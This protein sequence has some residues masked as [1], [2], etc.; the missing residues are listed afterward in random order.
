MVNET[1]YLDGVDALSVGIRLREP[2]TF[3]GATPIIDTQKIPGRN[4]VLT[5][6]T[7]AYKNRTAEARC[8]S[9]EENVQNAVAR[10]SAFL[11][12]K[13]GYRRLECS[14]DTD[15]FW[16]AMVSNGAS[17]EDRARLLNPFEIKFDCMP[18][19]WAKSG[20]ESIEFTESGSLYNN[21]GG[22]ALPLINVYGNGSGTINI[23]NYEVIVKSIDGVLHLDSETQNAYNETG[24]QNMNISAPIF[25]E[26]EVGNNG[27]SF[28]GDITKLEI[29]PRWWDF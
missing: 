14:N 25:P 9:L 1:F 27:V 7:G 6:H 12:S 23:G 5:F 20:E 21:F 4:G 15:H 16:K 28:T 18:Q 17:V 8:F 2:I 26:L 19:R 10:A 3:S 11:L 13:R 24:N 22:V 29:I